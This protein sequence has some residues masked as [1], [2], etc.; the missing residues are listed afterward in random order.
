MPGSPFLATMAPPR[1]LTG[2]ILRR[3]GEVL[4]RDTAILQA[5]YRGVSE[6]GSF[7]EG[8]QFA[9]TYTTP[10]DPAQHR[11]TYGRFDNPTWTALEAALGV[12][13]GGDAISF[14]SGMA[15]IAAVFGVCLKPGDVVVLPAESYY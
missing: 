6:A 2:I 7:V 11:L 1:N 15:A 12:L 4:H 13:D 3:K 9:S 14:A 5:G 10:G 8:P